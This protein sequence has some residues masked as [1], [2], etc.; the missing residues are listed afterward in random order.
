MVSREQ[1][2]INGAPVRIHGS[3]DRE[4]Q[5]DSGQTVAEMEVVVI[6][7]GRLPN[8]QFMQQISLNQ[9]R[10]DYEEGQSSIAMMTHVVNHSAV[11]SGDGEGTVYRHD[12]TFREFPESYQRRAAERAAKTVIEAEPPR[13]A[14]R[15][16]AR[17][18]DSVQEISDVRTAAD[19]SVW[20]E[21]IMQLKG[22]APRPKAPEEP[23]TVAELGAI[24]TVLTN[25]RME[26]LI[27]QLEARGVL[28]RG[29]V[30]ATFRAL[31]EKRFVIDATPLVG[32]RVAQ[33]A[34]RELQPG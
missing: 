12:I 13:R 30:D 2:Q 7:R 3:Y 16:L 17:T 23:M 33:R 18:D 19:P 8:K 15:D 25:L 21:A 22:N 4:V 20:A 1:L 27:Q 34:A 24:E 28:P 11:A 14:L 6:I 10:L 31:L 5:D 26:A 29:A 32:E 9:V